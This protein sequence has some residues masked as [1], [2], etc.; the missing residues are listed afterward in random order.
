MNRVGAV[1]YSFQYSLGLFS[2]SKREGARF[3]VFRL[4]AAMR[5]AGAESAQI[6]HSLIDHVAITRR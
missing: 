6:F 2:Y 1:C 4:V 5:E 3:D